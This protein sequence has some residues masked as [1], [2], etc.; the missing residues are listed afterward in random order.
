[1]DAS[2]IAKLVRLPNV[3]I[4]FFAVLL[5]GLLAGASSTDQW[6]VVSLHSISVAGFMSAWN[7][8]N[9]LMDVE[10]DQI[11]H[12]NRPLVSGRTSHSTARIIAMMSLIISIFG[13]LAAAAWVSFTEGDLS[14]WLPSLP[15]W[16][17]ALIL[18]IH[19]E[20][21]GEHS[22]RLKHKG[23]PGNLAVSLLVG[24]VI[25]FGAAAVGD[26]TN[27]LVLCVGLSAFSINS[28]RE[29][30]KDVEDMDG[31]VN[32]ETLSMKIGS[33]QARIVAWLMTLIGFGLLFLP[34]G[35]DLL[36]SGFLIAMV[37][38]ILTLIAAKPHIHSGN[39]HSAQRMLRLAMLLGLIGFGIASVL[40]D[41]LIQ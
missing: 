12:P 30:I 36:P 41:V 20:F 6:I 34:F 33:N 9:D 26:A 39:D 15:I 27:P 13:L 21:E 25:V 1:M 3:L 23:L 32:R 8:Y 5:G 19:Y 35:L 2:S 17:L 40:N 4:G 7:V 29:I 16:F 38:S 10:G 24:I 37:P 11:N 14:A 31:D 18:M 22:L 28:A